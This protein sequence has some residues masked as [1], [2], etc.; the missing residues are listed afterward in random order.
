MRKEHAITYK[1]ELQIVDLEYVIKKANRLGKIHADV[2]GVNVERDA[3][4]FHLFFS[5]N[6]GR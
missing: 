4:G 6:D 1:D 2:V 5:V 3:E